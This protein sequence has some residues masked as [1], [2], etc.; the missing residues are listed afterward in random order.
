MHYSST[1]MGT[2]LCIVH[3]SRRVDVGILTVKSP[4][5]DTVK[6]GHKICQIFVKISNFKEKFGTTDK[7]EF[8]KDVYYDKKKL[9]NGSL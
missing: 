3:S 6:A 4:K 7:W 5:N 2:S 9:V 8:R 1:C